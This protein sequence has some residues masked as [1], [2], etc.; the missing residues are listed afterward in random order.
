MYRRPAGYPS[1]KLPRDDI[2]VL[3]GVF[4]AILGA[5]QQSFFSRFGKRGCVRLQA[6]PAAETPLAA[7][8]TKSATADLCA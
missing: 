7:S 8:C 1:F 6:W 2:Q 3:G 5:P 4:G